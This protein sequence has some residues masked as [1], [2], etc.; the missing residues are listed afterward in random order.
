MTETFGSSVWMREICK[1]YI[2]AAGQEIEEIY[3]I[4]T[5]STLLLQALKTGQIQNLGSSAA[6][7]V[8]AEQMARLTD[9]QRQALRGILPQNSFGGGATGE[10]F[11]CCASL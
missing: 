5:K 9:E 8:S 7:G 10:S 4:K 11:V 1:K 6:M 2:Y 3:E